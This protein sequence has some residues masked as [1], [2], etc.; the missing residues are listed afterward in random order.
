MSDEKAIPD[1]GAMAPAFYL[2]TDSGEKLRLSSLKGQ[3]VVLFFYPK[4][5]TPGC[6]IEAQEFRDT[7]VDFE[8][9]GVRVLGISPDSVKSHCGFIEKQSLDFTLLADTE[10][11]AAEKYGVWVEKKSYGR[12]YWGVQRT[13]FLIDAGGKIA[14]VWPK[15]KPKGHAEA[16]LEAARELVG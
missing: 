11:V 7:Q 16:V 10:K 3:P 6:T 1:V 2:D 15:V 13:T 14:V 4:D 8:T 9:L 5:N 12:V